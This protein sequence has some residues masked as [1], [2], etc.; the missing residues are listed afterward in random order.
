MMS[1]LHP[2]LQRGGPVCSQWSGAVEESHAGVCDVHPVWSAVQLPAVTCVS[3]HWQ[4]D[5]HGHQWHYRLEENAVKLLL[6]VV[7]LTFKTFQNRVK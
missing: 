5:P 7:C 1:F 2:S 6:V 3:P 4:I